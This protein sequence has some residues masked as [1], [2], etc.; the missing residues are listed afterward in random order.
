MF[1]LLLYCIPLG[2]GFAGAFSQERNADMRSLLPA[3]ETPA[4]WSSTDTARIY[5]GDD[6]FSLIDGGAVL[7]FEFGFDKVLA[8]T[9]E[10]RSGSSVRLEIYRMKDA[11]AAYGI[12]SVRSG[13]RGRNAAFGQEATRHADYVMFRKGNYYVSVAGSDS[14]TE[15][16]GGTETLAAAVARALTVTRAK[17]SLLELLPQE[18]LLKTWYFRGT[19]GLSTVLPSMGEEMVGMIDGVAGKYEDRTLF[20]LRYPNPEQSE[21]TAERTLTTMRN[22]KRFSDYRSEGGIA[23]ANGPD[24][25]VLGLARTAS[26]ILLVVSADESAAR[27]SV[28]RLLQSNR[29]R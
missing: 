23:C 5:S 22:G 16:V 13:D 11:G 12:Y 27:N 3:R 14:S 17:P 7:F 10:N 26:Y 24:G 1:R 21:R 18:R 15:C 28:S 8:A 29:F 20:I 25:R 19:L 4:G 2:L 9:H 6:L